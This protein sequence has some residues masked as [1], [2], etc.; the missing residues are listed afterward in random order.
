MEIL[1][2]FQN[3]NYYFHNESL[4]LSVQ[5]T[6][7]GQVNILVV[8]LTFLTLWFCLSLQALG[9]LKLIS[10]SHQIALCSELGYQTPQLAHCE[11]FINPEDHLLNHSNSKS[12]PGVST[13]DEPGKPFS[14]L[15][16]NTGCSAS[17]DPL[18]CLRAVPFEVG[19]ISSLYP[20]I[21]AHFLIRLCCQL[22]IT[23]R[24]PFWMANSGSHP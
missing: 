4:P 20:E 6:I 9:A 15:L 22:R 10:S 12:S 5:V 11:I 14:Q 19:S 17:K 18:S 1:Q 13:Y 2:R 24:L 7:W 23:W 8:E 3:Q 16:I 21:V